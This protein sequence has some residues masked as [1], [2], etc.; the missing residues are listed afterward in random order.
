MLTGPGRLTRVHGAVALLAIGAYLVTPLGAAGPEGDPTGFAINLRFLVPALGLGI[1]IVPLSRWFDGGWPPVAL[2]VLLVGLFIGTSA[3]DP[4]ISA[5]GRRFGFALALLLV[6]LPL[7]A[8]LARE[9]LSRRVGI[10]A[11][12]AALGLAA[13]VFVLFA[14]PLQKSYFDNR[15]KHFEQG[16]GLESAYRWANGISDARIALA[17]STAGFKQF[18]FRGPDLT[19][20]IVYIGREAPKGGFDA[21]GTCEEFAEAVNETA[22]DY[23]VTSPFLN[24]NGDE[25]IASP[26]ADWI[27]G[28][29]AVSREVEPAGTGDGVGPVTVWRVEGQLDPSL[30]ERLDPSRDY[31]PG[32][33]DDA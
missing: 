12:A 20:E 26:E 23:L 21:I 2:G 19:N 17:G 29:P 10:P 15:Y 28:D 24:F 3:S 1:V 27:S 31:I 5:P 33:A 4:V 9:R 18:G 7:V 11:L 13:L 25:P 22:P 8:W 30:C 16:T 14:W 6:A 32:L